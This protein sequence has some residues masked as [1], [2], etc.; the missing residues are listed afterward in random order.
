M[1]LASKAVDIII[2]SIK[3]VDRERVR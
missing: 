3:K 2:D 1:E